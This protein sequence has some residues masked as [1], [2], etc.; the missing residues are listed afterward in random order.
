MFICLY[1]SISN[2]NQN[3][4]RQN[5]INNKTTIFILKKILE[6]SFKE[7]FNENIFNISSIIKD[8]LLTLIKIINDSSS[9]EKPELDISIN[10]QIF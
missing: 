6:M 3:F 2:I 7:R 9:L 4:I 8:Q 10:I 5:Y 1:L